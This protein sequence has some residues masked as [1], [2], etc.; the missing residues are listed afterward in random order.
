M[1]HDS[2]FEPAGPANHNG[3]NALVDDDALEHVLRAAFAPH[4]C[5]VRFQ[6]DAFS[7]VCKVALTIRVAASAARVPER[8]FVV[9]GVAVVK[10]RTAEALAEYV[11]D[12][13]RQLARRRVVFAAT[14]GNAASLLRDQ[15]LTGRATPRVG[16]D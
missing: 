10:L 6:Q 12:V 16:R 1:K 2:P 5:S 11:E 13:Q 8:E 3:R 14:R 15:A 9:E 4:R 7:G